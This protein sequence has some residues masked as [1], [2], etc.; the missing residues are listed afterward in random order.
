WTLGAGKTRSF[1]IQNLSTHVGRVKGSEI[2]FFH[3]YWTKPGEY[4]LAASFHVA[5]SPIPKGAA[6]ADGGYG[7]VTV[8]SNPV[9]LKVV[10]SKAQGKTDPPGA[11]LEL[12]L[13]AK[14]DTYTLDLGGKTPEEVRKVVKE[15]RLTT[16]FPP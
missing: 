2:T 6:E 4:T 7:Y 10:D 15:L 3:N 9:K 5:V 13:V 12:K 1:A 16:R 8:P 14:K 11:P